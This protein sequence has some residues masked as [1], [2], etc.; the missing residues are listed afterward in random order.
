M[1]MRTFFYPLIASSFLLLGCE[2]L[3]NPFGIDTEPKLPGERIVV[4]SKTSRLSIDPTAQS[5]PFTPPAAQSVSVWPVQHGNSQHIL[6]HLNWN[7]SWSKRWSNNIGTSLS[8][9]HPLQSPPIIAADQVFVLDDDYN[10]TAASILDG[11]EIWQFNNTTDI[12][13]SG[14]YGGGL[15]LAEGMLI[16]TTGYGDV[17]ALDPFSG[18][19]KWRVSLRIPI[20][21]AATIHQKQAIV[22]TLDSQAFAYSLSD[23]AELWYHAGI[24]EIT[25]VINQTTPASDGKRVFLAYNSGEIAAI[26]PNTGE[27]L[28]L[29]ALS[30]VKQSSELA[31][32]N[33][34]GTSPIV[35]NDALLVSG[36][37]GQTVLFNASTG[38]RIWD[39]KI[40]TLHLPWVSGNVIFMLAN[41]G[42]LYALDLFSGSVRWFIQPDELLH[43]HQNPPDPTAE[44][45]VIVAKDFETQRWS[46]PIL[47]DG[48]LLL[49]GQNGAMLKIH[50]HDGTL[51]NVVELDSG[52]RLP[53]QIVGDAAL[54]LEESGAI[55]VYN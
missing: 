44:T 10:V 34:I 11:K 50:P 14:A 42:W 49:L 28:W 43:L 39:Q 5:S 25:S 3:I 30:S 24:N 33:T 46:A 7:G 13:Y 4:L 2:S 52:S 38:Q 21:G 22:Q 12:E 17:F 9:E 37:G 27:P 32:I 15:A 53:P 48:H 8:S 26:D 51:S 19:E 54:I 18:D 47:V 31:Q 41:D 20:R 45:G 55:S 29:D 23:G 6:H 35:I 1:I 16:V 40:G 36:Y